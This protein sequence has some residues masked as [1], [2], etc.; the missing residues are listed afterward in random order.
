MTVNDFF[1][2]DADK[3]A[4]RISTYTTER[5]R[6]QEVVKTRQKF[7]G[8]NATEGNL[9]GFEDALGFSF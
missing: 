4:H 2:F 7:A 3:H 6:K 1:S 8:P 9:E 5:L